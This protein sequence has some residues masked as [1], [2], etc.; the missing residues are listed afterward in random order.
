MAV[1]VRPFMSM[2]I[3][4]IRF[5]TEQILIVLQQLLVIKFTVEGSPI[6]ISNVL[7]QV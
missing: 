7:G 3:T 2:E 5:N 4:E 1:Y 6:H